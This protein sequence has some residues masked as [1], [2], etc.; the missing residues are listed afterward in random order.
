MASHCQGSSEGYSAVHRP[1]RLGPCAT[2]FCRDVLRPQ[3]TG[4]PRLSRNQRQAGVQGVDVDSG[5]FPA[6]R[7]SGEAEPGV[8]WLR[9]QLGARTLEPIK[10]GP[11]QHDPQQP[12]PSQGWTLQR[13]PGSEQRRRHSRPPAKHPLVQTAAPVSLGSVFPGWSGGWVGV[14]VC[15]F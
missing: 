12:P 11:P 3:A 9:G 2:R 4:R 13:T 5:G 14:C 10:D 1:W 6:G 15:W 8:G 7:K